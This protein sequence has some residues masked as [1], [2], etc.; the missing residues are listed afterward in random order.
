MIWRSFLNEF[1][2]RAPQRQSISRPL[3]P[4]LWSKG[5]SQSCDFKGS[6]DYWLL[7]TES[8]QTDSYFREHY[9]SARGLVW[10]RL[11]SRSRERLPCDLD[12]FVTAALPSIRDPFILITGDGDASV[13]A[14][15]CKD[16]VERLLAS[17]WLVKWYTQNFVGRSGGKIA[18][19]PIGLDL[20]SS[21]LPGG[22]E[23]SFSL[24]RKISRGRIPAPES[25][26][27][28]FCDL[29]VSPVS[30]DRKQAIAALKD[31]GH[32]D[33]LRRR[34]S[35]RAIWKRYADYPFVLSAPGHGLDCHRTWELV[36]LGCIVITR[37]SPLDPLFDGLPVVI[38]DDW[39]EVR[40]IRNLEKW[41]AEFGPLTAYE[42][43]WKR[44]RPTA[45]IDPL[46]NALDSAN[47]EILN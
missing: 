42:K 4:V 9:S 1:H 6:D 44:L 8:H 39:K 2:S 47:N 40:E 18:P 23:E 10:V 19:L 41:R 7:D 35:Q 27:R 17:P 45:F 21:R 43:I 30:D 20:H 16:T 24:L 12:T 3:P 38:V 5:Y 26:L 46:R 22:P 34:I 29:G 33:F 11:G 25:R 14:D 31:C 37:T 36:Y 32:V 15:L 28:V 13:P